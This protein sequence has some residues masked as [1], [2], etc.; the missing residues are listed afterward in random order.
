MQENIGHLMSAEELWQGRLDDYDNNVDTLRPA[1][2]SN[3]R[4]HEAKHNE[5]PAASILAGFRR[6]RGRLVER[7]EHLEPERFGQTVLHPRLNKP[8]RI[9]DM[10]YFIAEHDDYHLARVAELRRAGSTRA[11]K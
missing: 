9:V 4:T 10:M 2:M 11:A 1:D 7:L 3:R 5:Q 6:E 8:M